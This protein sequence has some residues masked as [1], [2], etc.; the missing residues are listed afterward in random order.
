MRR[1][2]LSRRWGFGR[3]SGG[4][5]LQGYG[6]EVGTV[7]SNTYKPGVLLSFGDRQRIRMI[8]GKWLR[9]QGGEAD[10][11]S[12]A[13]KVFYSCCEAGAKMQKSRG[14]EEPQTYLQARFSITSL[15][16]MSAYKGRADKYGREMVL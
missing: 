10:G 11:N 9:V 16:E 13:Q 3:H 6:S 15:N 14:R 5:N 1:T 8:V 4:L 2:L 7:N 12:Q